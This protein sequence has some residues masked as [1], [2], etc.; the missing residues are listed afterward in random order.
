MDRPVRYAR[1]L[2]RSADHGDRPVQVSGENGSVT[3]RNVYGYY[4]KK[5]GSGPMVPLAFCAAIRDRMYRSFVPLLGRAAAVMFS[6]RAVCGT[7]DSGSCLL[8]VFVQC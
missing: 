3:A 1:P 5:A 8:V 4:V 2:G 7:R 6:E